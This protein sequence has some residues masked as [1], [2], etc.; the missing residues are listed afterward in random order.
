MKIIDNIKVRQIIPIIIG[1]LLGYAFYYFIGCK[2]G[3]PIQSNPFT[4]TLYGALIGGILS[5]PTKSKKE[6]N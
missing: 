2:N 6:K 1:G 3:C 5:V 4:S